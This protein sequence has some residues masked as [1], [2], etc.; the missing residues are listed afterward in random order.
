MAQSLISSKDM[1]NLFAV[2]LSEEK[3][4]KLVDARGSKGLFSQV[5]DFQAF[6]KRLESKI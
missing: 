4:R 1:Q 2:Q 6:A 3:F 5:D